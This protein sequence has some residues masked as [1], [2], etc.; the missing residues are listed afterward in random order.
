MSYVPQRIISK[1]SL[2][3]GLTSHIIATYKNEN[4][5]NQHITSTNE[6]WH[7]KSYYDFIWKCAHS[8]E[9][10]ISREVDSF[11]R[12][13][14]YPHTHAHITDT[15][16]KVSSDFIRTSKHRFGTFLLSLASA[17]VVP[18]H[19]D[20]IEWIALRIN[21]VVL[22]WNFIAAKVKKHGTECYLRP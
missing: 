17:A 7:T 22:I 18:F 20:Q 11:I 1:I 21:V 13:L 6:P 15:V 3:F 9:W 5:D 16:L 10:N 8:I 2:L 14:F 19:I 4:N 12:F